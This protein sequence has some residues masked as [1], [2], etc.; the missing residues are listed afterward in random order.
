MVTLRAARNLAGVPIV[1]PFRR[2]QLKGNRKEYFAVDVK[3]PYRLIFR[4]A[5]DPLP[6]LEDGGIDLKAVTQIEIIGVE[7]YH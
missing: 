7:D 3:H 5:N 1:P 2:H 4:P 6:K